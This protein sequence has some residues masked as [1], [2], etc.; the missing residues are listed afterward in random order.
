M[1]T[2]VFL[3]V[4]LYSNNIYIET[5][6]RPV[7]NL[8]SMYNIKGWKQILTL[9]LQVFSINTGFIFISWYGN[10]HNSYHSMKI[11]P[12]FIEKI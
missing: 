5:S 3:T 1:H 2:P 8:L 4:N 11:N 9:N 10:Y 7:N 6:L 12:V